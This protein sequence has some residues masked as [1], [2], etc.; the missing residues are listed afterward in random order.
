MSSPT[1]L[2]CRIR[3]PAYH[4]RARVGESYTGGVR[5]W[6]YS[7]KAILLAAMLAAV[8]VYAQDNSA[9][10]IDRN[11][12]QNGS[13]V[14]QNPASTPGSVAQPADPDQY[15]SA[16]NP[17]TIDGSARF[18]DLDQFVTNDDVY[19]SPIGAL[20]QHN[21]VQLATRQL[22][23]GLAVLEVRP[24][25]A[26]AMAGIRPYSGLVHTLLGA[27]VVGASM[28]F[29]PAFAAIGLVDN[30]HVGEKFDLIIGV[31]GRRVHAI[32]DFQS[33]LAEARLGDILYVTIVRNGKR[34]QLP[35]R[36][37]A[38]N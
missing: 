4:F 33:A 24:G 15:D 18:A 29:P 22:V 14:N 26:A 36:V 1:R 25:S 7:W 37:T 3:N 2:R 10:E 27:T 35:I 28:F 6:T 5:I 30:N 12:S 16:I 20:L 34:L 9:V 32:S 17:N 11:V 23:C 31:D 19:Q 38:Q 21:C 13:E 8:P